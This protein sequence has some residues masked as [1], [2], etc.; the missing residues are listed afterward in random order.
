MYYLLAIF[1]WIYGSVQGILWSSYFLL[2]SWYV[3]AIL[4]LS[5]GHILAIWSVSS[6]H[7]SLSYGYLLAILR[8]TFGSFRSFHPT[9]GHRFGHLL[10]MFWGIICASSVDILRKIFWSSSYHPVVWL[11]SSFDQFL[12]IYWPFW[13]L[14]TIL[15]PHFN[16]FYFLAIFDNFWLHS[17][18]LLISF[19][20]L[21]PISWPSTA[22]LLR[23]FWSSSSYF[24]PEIFSLFFG[25]FSSFQI[26]VWSFL[27]NLLAVVWPSS[28][29]LLI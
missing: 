22:H 2:F 8:A 24:L 17:A 5:F 11:Q 26:I 14:L 19:G 3:L 16:I 1:L 27:G 20:Y 21:L 13:I 29:H 9:S 18:N 12:A 4:C 7:I 28:A 25:I 10:A 6:D 23:I 15:W